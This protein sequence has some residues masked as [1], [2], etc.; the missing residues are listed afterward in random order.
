MPLTAAVN[1]KNY[2]DQR[3]R[4]FPMAAAVVIYKGALVG[5]D[6]TSKMAK[7]FQV[8][9]YFVGI[10]AET[11]DNSAGAASAK[12]VPVETEGDFE[13]PLSGAVVT[14]IGFRVSASADDSIIKVASANRIVGRIIGLGS[15]ANTVIVR[16]KD[17]M[18]EVTAI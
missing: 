2:V 1:R 12:S 15:T 9:D 4:T 16:L 10:A 7:P 3:I 17:Y 14:D 13:L 18:E 5:I 8:G 11:V 6:A